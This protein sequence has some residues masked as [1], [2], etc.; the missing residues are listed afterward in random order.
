VK[1]SNLALLNLL[2]RFLWNGSNTMGCVY[3]TIV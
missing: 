2:T 3:L 1:T